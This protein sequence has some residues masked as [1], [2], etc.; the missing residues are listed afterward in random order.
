MP[1]LDPVTI[2][3]LP[4]SW[5]SIAGKTTRRCRTAP[6]QA[7]AT[8]AVVATTI[9]LARHGETDWNREGRFQGHADPPLNETRARPGA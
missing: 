1:R 6:A 4:A 8:V 9:L 7:V 2:A 3:I 5:R